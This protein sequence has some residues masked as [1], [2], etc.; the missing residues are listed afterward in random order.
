MSENAPP[1]PQ[2][3]T[4]TPKAALVARPLT[5]AVAKN[6]NAVLIGSFT[7]I[8]SL[9]SAYLGYYFAGQNQRRMLTLEYDKLRAEH[10]LQI[11]KTLAT[12]EAHM[13]AFSVD[14]SHALMRA[15]GLDAQT[16]SLAAEIGKQYPLTLKGTASQKLADLDRHVRYKVATDARDLWSLQIEMLKAE[17][18]Q[19]MDLI[20]AR[21]KSF[22][23]LNEKLMGDVAA[24]IHIFHRDRAEDYMQLIVGFLQLNNEAQPLLWDAKC[25]NEKKFED[26]GPRMVAWNAQASN[27][28]QSLGIAIKP[29]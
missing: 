6:M 19:I 24:T 5:A 17:E 3:S 16:G 9:M 23:D 22:N 12:A 10:T 13:T 1:P 14:A 28:A 4:P 26:L 7:I 11:A 27:F 29:E 2:A 18:T 15:C 25:S 8:S 21:L 20:N